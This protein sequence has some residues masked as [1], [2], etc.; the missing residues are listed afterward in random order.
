MQDINNSGD[1]GIHGQLLQNNG[2][3]GNNPSLKAYAAVGG[4][5]LSVDTANPLSTAI[6]RSLK[7]SVPSGTTGQ[8]GFSNS[9]YLGVPVNVDTYANYFWIKG[10]YS[11]S[12]TLQLVGA[13][14]GTVY[15][16]K[17]ITVQSVASAFT[18]YETTYTSTQAPDGNNIWKLTFNGASVAGSA[19]YFD[20]VQLFPVT[21][22]ARFAIPLFLHWSIIR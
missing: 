4:V 16:T 12:V 18:Y 19:L 14:S 8:V 13:T 3:Q 15:A 21:Y 1:G 7:V 6:T 22:H 10:A 5:T 11:G 9:G 17:T 2:F 20:L